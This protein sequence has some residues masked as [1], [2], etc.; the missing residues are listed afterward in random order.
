MR[1]HRTETAEAPRGQLW[2]GKVWKLKLALDT[3]NILG[4]G[5]VKDTY[6]LLGEGIRLVVRGSRNW[7]RQAPER[8]HP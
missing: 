1:E 3:T 2:R 5:A 7:P 6:I 4:R 8:G